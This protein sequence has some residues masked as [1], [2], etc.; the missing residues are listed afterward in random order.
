[1]YQDRASA[2]RAL[3]RS[4]TD[5][6]VAVL[7]RLARGGVPVAAEVAGALQVRACVAIPATRDGF[8][9]GHQRR[10]WL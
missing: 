8:G 9:Y 7:L 4:L 5:L 10:V 1:M 3:A 2:G 6:S